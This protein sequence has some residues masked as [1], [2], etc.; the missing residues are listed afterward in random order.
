[1]PSGAENRLFVDFAEPDRFHA[2]QNID[3]SRQSRPVRI[4]RIN[5]TLPDGPVPRR[6]FAP[7]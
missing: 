5:S 6:E 4:A 2:V 7:Q 1:M 3:N